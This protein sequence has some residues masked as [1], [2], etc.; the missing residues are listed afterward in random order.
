MDTHSFA[1]VFELL[2][3]IITIIITNVEDLNLAVYKQ[4]V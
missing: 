1:V 2:F 3:K 4:E